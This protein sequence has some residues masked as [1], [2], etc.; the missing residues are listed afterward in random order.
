MIRPESSAWSTS[1]F[2]TRMGAASN[3]RRFTRLH[4]DDGS[5]AYIP[6]Q[7]RRGIDSATN[8]GLGR[9]GDKDGLSCR[10]KPS[11]AELGEVDRMALRFLWPVV[12]V[13]VV[14]CALLLWFSSIRFAMAPTAPP[15]PQPDHEVWTFWSLAA[16]PVIGVVGI[17]TIL[18]SSRIVKH[19]ATI[20]GV[21]CTVMLLVAISFAVTAMIVA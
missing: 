13:M 2:Q 7:L 20:V 15:T 5:L 4:T 19:R 16:I 21:G 3:R 10:T 17:A 14:L 12:V 8:G 11:E 1:F 18:L 9:S 6:I